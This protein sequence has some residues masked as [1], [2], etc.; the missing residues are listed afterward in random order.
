MKTTTTDNTT[1]TTKRRGRPPKSNTEAV[2]KPV[3]KRKVTKAKTSPEEEMKNQAIPEVGDVE[4]ISEP[5]PI[6]DTPDT[7]TSDT[8]ATTKRRGRKK[9]DDGNVS[10]EPKNS[11]KS[12]WSDDRISDKGSLPI[13]ADRMKVEIQ[14]LDKSLGMSPSDPENLKYTAQKEDELD[15][16]GNEP[17]IE[18]RGCTVWPR[19]KFIPGEAEG[20]WV[21][22]NEPNCPTVADEETTELPF[23]YDY[24]I[25]GMFKDDCGLLTRAKNN[26][27]S[28]LKAYKKQIDGN[29]FVL[30][31][32]IGF[33]IPECY[34]NDEGDWVD[35]FN[36]ETKRLNTLARPLRISGPSGERS[37]IA[38]S[39]V[40]PPLSTIKFEILMTSQNLRPVIEEWLDYGLL[41]GLGQWR[42]SGIGIYRWRE[43]GD[44][45]NPIEEEEEEK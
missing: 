43:L 2:K 12:S 18:E 45:W 13:I 27:S 19:A 33:N 44:D 40:M 10:D 16:Y 5:A 15:I 28:D 35:S 38:I 1:T 42:N 9:K 21:Q 37:A 14:L 32:K 17:P 30:P 29:I 26:L 7:T 20:V 22:V 3:A 4:N 41:R 34:L 23:I 6:P 31:R 36:P 39:E 8:T 24:Q 11:K 25:R